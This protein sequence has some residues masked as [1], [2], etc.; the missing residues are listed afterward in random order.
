MPRLPK[1]RKPP[2]DVLQPLITQLERVV[3]L[4]RP[5]QSGQSAQQ[6]IGS[7]ARI[8]TRLASWAGDEGEQTSCN[9]RNAVHVLR[10][11]R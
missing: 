9:V 2:S 7:V 4:T 10:K 5:R 8:V 3:Y 6:M 1:R 11:R